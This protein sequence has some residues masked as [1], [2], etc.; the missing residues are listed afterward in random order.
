[1][2]SSTL[3][4]KIKSMPVQFSEAVKPMVFDKHAAEE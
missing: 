2:L 3:Q 1:V 4:V